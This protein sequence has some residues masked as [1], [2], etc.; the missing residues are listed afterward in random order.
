MAEISMLPFFIDC[1]PSCS[2][3]L[4]RRAATLFSEWMDFASCVQAELARLSGVEILLVMNMS[5]TCYP[6]LLTYSVVF[7]KLTVKCSNAFARHYE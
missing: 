7:S 1:R 4:S 3:F 6:S 2:C 5:R